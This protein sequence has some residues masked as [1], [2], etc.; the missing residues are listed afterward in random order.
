VARYSPPICAAISTYK[1]PLL[2]DVP[3]EMGV[4][5]RPLAAAMRNVSDEAYLATV[6]RLLPRKGVAIASKGFKF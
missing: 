5:T 1:K 6:V 3:E 4:A 2:S